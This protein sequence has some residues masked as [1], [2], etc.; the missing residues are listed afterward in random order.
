MQALK[1]RAE[2]QA[3]DESAAGDAWVSDDLVATTKHGTP[4][5]PRNFNR[6]FHAACRHAD[7][8]LIKVHD[9]RRMCASLLAAL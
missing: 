9:T 4:Y 1:E 8:R 6:H 7:V 2:Q 5:E 3:A